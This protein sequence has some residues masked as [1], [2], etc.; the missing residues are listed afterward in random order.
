MSDTNDLAGPEHLFLGL[1]ADHTITFALTSFNRPDLLEKTLDSFLAMNTY[2]IYKY[3]ITEDSG[4]KGV[5]DALM[6][7]YDYLNIEWII[8]ETR[9]GQI[10]SIDNMYKKI[11]TKYIFHCEEDWLFTDKSFI[12]KSLVILEK[13]PKIFQV[14]LRDHNDTNGHPVE[15]Y[16][17]EFDLLR[18]GYG[19]WNGFSFNPGLRR[20]SDYTLV[21]CYSDIGHEAK[22]SIKYRELGYRAAILKEKHVEHLGWDRHINQ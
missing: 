22:I 20:L 14:W 4:I 1:D 17:K 13:H 7:K 16:S 11:T 6:K 5:N 10:K 19:P 15:F 8:N 18:L 9:L 2:P 12:E 3:L 21:G